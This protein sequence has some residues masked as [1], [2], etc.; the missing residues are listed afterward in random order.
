[1]ALDT[2]IGG[3][4]S[5]SYGTLADYESYVVANIDANFNGHGHDGAHEMHLRRAAQ[6]LDRNF[7]FIGVKQYREQ[8]M[9]WPRLTDKLVSGWP[10]DPD[11]VPQ[12]IIN[13]QF[14]AAYS[15]EFDGIDPFA[16]LTDGAVRATRAKAGPVETQTEYALPRQTPRIVAIEGLL[17]DYVFGGGNS[18]QVRMGRG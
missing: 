11:T 8:S 1:M 12:S 15:F 4:S 18:G 17:R 14:E 6:Y 10:I 5:D 13:A 7:G 3:A 16:T 2:T 9:S